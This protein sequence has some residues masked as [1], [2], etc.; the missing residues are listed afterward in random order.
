M[1]RAGLWHVLR[2]QAG[3]SSTLALAEVC[4]GNFLSYRPVP[5]SHCLFSQTNGLTGLKGVI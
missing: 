4:F 5:V 1:N 2:G 3:K